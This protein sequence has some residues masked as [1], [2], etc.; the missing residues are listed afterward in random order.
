MESRGTI[1]LAGNKTIFPQKVHEVHWSHIHV[2][3]FHVQQ[4]R[5]NNSTRNVVISFQQ[6][7]REDQQT[8]KKPIVL[9]VDVIDN[10]ETS[11]KTHNGSKDGSLIWTCCSNRSRSLG[12]AVKYDREQQESIEDNDR[13]SLKEYG[14]HAG[15]L[16]I[17]YL[18][19]LVI[20]QTCDM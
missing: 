1:L 13:Q 15:V 11:V 3:M 10:D 16:K 7:D 12:V 5:K 17:F 19:H 4:H 6:G 20:K 8:K 18:Q 2:Y 14:G 9:E